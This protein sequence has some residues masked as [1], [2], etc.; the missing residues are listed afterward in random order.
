[1]C[2]RNF[3]QHSKW[4]RGNRRDQFGLNS[5]VTACN[6]DHWRDRRAWFIIIFIERSVEPGKRVGGCYGKQDEF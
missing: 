5:I 6:S 4:W 2:R 1:M 3:I